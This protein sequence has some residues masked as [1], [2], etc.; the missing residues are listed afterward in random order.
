MEMQELK[1]TVTAPAAKTPEQT[2]AENQLGVVMAIERL[3]RAVNA[4]T[5][6]LSAHDDVL[7]GMNFMAQFH[8]QLVSQLPPALIEEVKKRNAP[9]P[10]PEATHEQPKA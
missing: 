2:A 4:G 5:Y 1:D 10:A 7:A 3:F 9:A 8:K 6:P